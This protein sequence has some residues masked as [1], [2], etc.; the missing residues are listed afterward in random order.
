M[1][2]KTG[3]EEPSPR[4]DDAEPPNLKGPLVDSAE[5][6]ASPSAAQKLIVK[7][8]SRQQRERDNGKPNCPG[9]DEKVSTSIYSNDL[10]IRDSL[11]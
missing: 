5:Q 1:R 11:T 4:A 10:G 9:R 3:I 8:P 6:T 2:A 7:Y